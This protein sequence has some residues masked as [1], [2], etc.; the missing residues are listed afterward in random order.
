MQNNFT[1]LRFLFALFVVVTHS[2]PLAGIF[3]GDYLN[4]LTNGQAEF[5]Y[6]GLSGFFIISGYLCFQSLER[7]KTLRDYYWKRAL[8]IFPGLFV[9]LLLTVVLGVFVYESSVGDYLVNSSMW[10]YLPANMSIVKQQLT[11][12]GIFTDNPYN[13]TI[14]GSLW[15]LEYEVIFYIWLS[16]LVFFPRK[17]KIILLSVAVTTLISS[18][19]FF[20]DEVGSHK[21]MFLNGKLMLE[22]GPYFFGGALLSLLRIEQIRQR[23][24]VLICLSLALAVACYL[25]YFTPAKFFILPPLVL[26][27]AT[28]S[29]NAVS[30]MIE[31]TGDLSYGIYIYAF[32]I[33]QTLMHF[34]NFSSLELMITSIP[35]SVLAGY[36]SWHLIEKRCLRYKHFFRREEV[37]QEVEREPV[38]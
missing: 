7:C 34:F 30:R 32:P 15:S 13:P 2:F 5:S 16:A 23:G 1:F 20:M 14:N 6:I 9:V 8:R 24:L 12:D 35:L 19:I 27:I 11:I 18:Y 29:A 22:F 38:S 28:A 4:T 3:T 37:R 26:L 21:Y 33:Q 31:R 25:N 36:A 10:T 17:V